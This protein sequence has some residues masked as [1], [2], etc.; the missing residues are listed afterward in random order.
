MSDNNVF[1]NNN[2]TLEVVLQIE[3]VQMLIMHR[4]YIN[5]F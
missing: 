4:T 2:G 5:L 3:V 1:E